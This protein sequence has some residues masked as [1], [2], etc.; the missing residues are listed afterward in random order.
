MEYMKQLT[1]KQRRLRSKGTRTKNNMK[2]RKS[3]KG[4][5]KT[6]KRVMKGGWG[7][8]LPMPSMLAQKK[9]ATNQE[10]TMYGGWGDAIE[11]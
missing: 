4:H 6:Y 7:L 3:Y 1:L 11:I 5:R 9:A 10:Q 2:R 8:Q